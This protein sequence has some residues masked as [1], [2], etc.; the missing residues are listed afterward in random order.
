M[1]IWTLKIAKT[2]GASCLNG[3]LILIK[4]NKETGTLVFVDALTNQPLW[5]TTP[6]RD[7]AFSDDRNSVVINTASGSV[8]EMINVSSII[9]T[10][11][12][13][14]TVVAPAK[15]AVVD[16]LNV[17]NKAFTSKPIKFGNGYDR[18]TFTFNR[19]I[20][21]DE[22]VKFLEDRKYTMHY[23]EGWWDD[24][25]EITGSKN[26]WAYTWVKVYTD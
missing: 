26:K 14:L 18:T 21:K 20:T 12:D 5:E 17:L 11:G 16:A 13:V 3:K 24:H 4:K 9:P 25:S 1:K 2:N 23:P 10:V 7:R 8:Y 22:F 19:D 6:I 15:V